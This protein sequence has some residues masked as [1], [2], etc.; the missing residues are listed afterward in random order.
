MIAFTRFFSIRSMTG[1]A[2]AAGF[3]LA[4]LGEPARANP[5]EAAF[6]K[7]LAGAWQGRGRLRRS[8][9]DN[10]EPVSCRLDNKVEGL[11]LKMSY[12]C[13]GFDLHFG[14][15]GT[16]VFNPK[17]KSYRGV[18]Y[19]TGQSGEATGRGRRTGNVLRLNMIGR[20]PKT[21]K[22]VKSIFKVRV[23]GNTLVNEITAKDLDTGRNF[24]VLSIRLKR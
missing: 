4:G 3:V 9:K 17:D 23:S 19:V 22:P 8:L 5:K 7:R 16:L 11:A 1:I 6:L 2:L 24:K 15:V 18:W 13:L 12:N 21:G 20:H 10:T 14:S